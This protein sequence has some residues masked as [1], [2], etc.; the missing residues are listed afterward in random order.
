MKKDYNN[1]SNT[2]YNAFAG[3]QQPTHIIDQRRVVR[4]LVSGHVQEPM[5]CAWV[6]E[7]LQ[8]SEADPQDINRLLIELL[9]CFNLVFR[10]LINL[11]Q[12]QA[13]LC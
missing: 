7:L 8:F 3:F 11:L 6:D 10:R 13:E 2:I 1:N 5:A 12:K 4:Q 9:G